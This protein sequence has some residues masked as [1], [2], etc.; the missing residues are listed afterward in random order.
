MVDKVHHVEVLCKDIEKNLRT[1]I[2]KFGF[3]LHCK[4]KLDGEGR[5]SY[6]VQQ[7]SML[8]VLTE[9]DQDT[10]VDIAFEVK[11]VYG[12]VKNINEKDV[13]QQVTTRS[14]NNGQVVSATVKTPVGNIVHSLLNLSKYRGVFLPGYV[15]CFESREES[16]GASEVAASCN[17]GKLMTHY[18]H[19]TYACFPGTSHAIIAWY[20]KYFDFSRF[21][22]NDSEDVDEGFIVQ[23]SDD[24]ASSFGMRLTAMEF[25]RCAEVGLRMNG[26]NLEGKVRIV[27]AEPLPG[28]G[29]NQ[30]SN[31]LCEHGGPGVQHIGLHSNDIINCIGTLKKRQV[32]FMTPPNTY[33]SEVG[34][35][36]EVESLGVC[37]EKLVKFGILLDAEF[38]A[39]I[40]KQVN[41]DRASILKSGKSNSSKRYLMQAFTKPVFDKE[42]FFLEIIQRCGATG[43]GAG[44]IRAL[45]KAIDAHLAQ[46][47][48]KVVKNDNVA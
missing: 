24:Q 47:Q 35:Q 12:L 3:T 45:W 26:R 28:Q 7:E 31:F 29:P 32:D 20:E 8:L 6:V 1:F 46:C 21:F 36:E 13:L 41:T 40:N 18:D 34:K 27:L 9:G 11:D 43:F 4:R 33:Y 17:V 14:D 2:D 5:R 44:N 23:S 10:V 30:V 25:W 39:D 37:F 16:E 48:S 19:I 42:T 22:I 38:D 15:K